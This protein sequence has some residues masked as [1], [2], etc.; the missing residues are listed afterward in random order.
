[1]SARTI[2]Q[3]PRDSRG[4]FL[5]ASAVPRSVDPDD[6]DDT[7]RHARAGRRGRPR[8]SLVKTTPAPRTLTV[9][10]SSW[11]SLAARPHPDTDTTG[12]R[13]HA[14]HAAMKA[15]LPATVL[16]W[17]L[18]PDGT[19]Y[20]YLPD[21]TLLS[22]PGTYGAAVTAITTCTH[23]AAHAALVTSLHG[24]YAA[25]ETADHCRAPHAVLTAPAVPGGPDAAPPFPGRT[26]GDLQVVPPP[27]KPGT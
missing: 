6:W 9:V 14:V 11:T 10:P 17:D 21:G 16:G 25:L 13:A 5:P 3:Q 20:Q 1:M 15:G 23:G 7:C 18:R 2:H 8:L 24:L 19:A 4:H 26:T 27:Q 22:H 12:A